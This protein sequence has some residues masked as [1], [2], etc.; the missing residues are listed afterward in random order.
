[1]NGGGPSFPNPANGSPPIV[2]QE[3]VP[4]SKQS[5][6]TCTSCQGRDLRRRHRTFWEKP[7]YAG[8]YRCMSCGRS[9]RIVRPTV[10]STWMGRKLRYA[11]DRCLQRARQWRPPTPDRNAQTIPWVSRDLLPEGILELET[12]LA[13]LRAKAQSGVHSEDRRSENS[14]TSHPTQDGMPGAPPEDNRFPQNLMNSK[15]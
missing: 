3:S 14:C 5:I 15:S 7:I 2:S 13:R 9:W 8:V 4:K 11:Y 6:A 10:A 12:Q 1:V